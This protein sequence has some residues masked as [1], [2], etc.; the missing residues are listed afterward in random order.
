[1]NQRHRKTLGFETPASKLQTGVALKAPLPKIT[2]V[3][4]AV[5]IFPERRSFAATG[6]YTLVNRTNDYID[7]I[8]V[9]EGKE[10]VDEI[11][12]DRAFHRRFS[13]KSHFYELYTLDQSLRPGETMRMDFRAS[14]ETK[15]FMD[16][17]ERPEL[18]Y[19]GT[20]FDRDYFPALGYS[21]QIELDEPVRR[22]EEKLG[23]LEDMAPRGDPYYTNVNL[24]SPDSEWVTFHCVVST[25]PDQIAIAP[26]YLK[27]NGRR[28]A[29][30]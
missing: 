29:R 13:D 25:S 23:E 1:M 28:T 8:H 3:D 16:G 30:Y 17:G 12:F 27:R 20:F 24:F 2:A 21:D 18:A 7:E 19:N 9:T 5:D 4:V 26:G 22:R 10:S 6:H 11:R 14:R 15:G